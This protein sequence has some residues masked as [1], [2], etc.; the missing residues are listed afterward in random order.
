MRPPSRINQRRDGYNTVMDH[1]RDRPRVA[2]VPGL[3]VR[4]YAVPAAE[5][6]RRAGLRVDL[7]P[8]PAWRGVPHDLVRYGRW[9]ADQLADRGPV[10]LMIGLSV[11]TQAAA[12]AATRG[13]VGRLLLVS[14]TVDPARRSRRGLMRTWLAGDHHPDS[15]TMIEQVPD[16]SRAGPVRIYRGMVSALRTPLEDVLPRV[17]APITIAH[18]GWDNLTSFGYA[19]ALAHSVDADLIELPDAPHSWPLGDTER[20]VATVSGLVGSEPARGPVTAG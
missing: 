2:I 5:A 13:G 18:A 3:A 7:L 6:L 4:S 10:D 20:F 1:S 15:Q 12:L 16:W 17:S 8:A 14:P 9:A 11:G 19:A